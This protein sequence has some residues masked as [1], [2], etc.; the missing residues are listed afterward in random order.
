MKTVSECEEKVLTMP[1][2]FDIIASRTK[3]MEL[4]R[5][6]GDF[7]GQDSGS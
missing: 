5:D 3:V 2:G 1:A 7:C 4:N 6:C